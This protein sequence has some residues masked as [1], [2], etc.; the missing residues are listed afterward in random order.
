M[1]QAMR[2]EKKAL[3]S[4]LTFML[5]AILFPPWGIGGTWQDHSY[6]FLFTGP[7]DVKLAGLFTYSINWELLI[8]ELLVLI[9]V[10][11]IACIFLRK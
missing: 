4:T 1:R 11:A 9:V 8:A 2:N 6:G 7:F 3:L 10:G 5:L